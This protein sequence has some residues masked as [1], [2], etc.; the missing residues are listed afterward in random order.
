MRPSA[1][2]TNPTPDTKTMPVPE[3]T[4]LR[5]RPPARGQRTL[6]LLPALAAALLTAAA[7][8]AP[9]PVDPSRLPPAAARKI[10]F[11]KD[12]Q[13]ILAASCHRC[14]GP[15]KEKGGL[16][17]DAKS[18][19]LAGGTS[20]PVILPGD[21][22]ASPLIH[23]VSGLDPKLKMPA[24]GDPL[25]AEQVGILRAWID[26]GAD[27]PD[28]ASAKLPDKTDH[29][30]FK[31]V[32]RPT[33][34]DVSHK[35]WPRNDVDRFV[36]AALEKQNL[37]P[38][39]EADRRTLL[40]R[41]YFDLTGLPPTPEETDAFL[42]DKAPDAYDKLVDRLLASPRYGERWAR[43]WLDVVRFADSHGFEMNHERPNAWHYRD[44]VIRSLNDDKP[45]DRFLREQIAGD[46]LGADEAT[47]FLVGGPM[48][49]VKSPDPGL[50]AQQRADELHDMVATT[51]SAMLGLTVGCARCHDHKFDPVSHTDYYRI[52][53]VFEGVQHGERP[54]RLPPGDPRDAQLA[55]ARQRL[56]EIDAE[57]WAFEPVARVPAAGAADP[58]K[59]PPRRPAVRYDRNVDRFPPVV[60]KFVRLTVLETENASQPCIDELE[61][62][63]TGPLPPRNVALASA[64]AKAT[65]SGAL[66]GFD[67]HKIEHIND[68]RPGNG[69]SW[70]SDE[71]GTGWVQ[72]E[73]PEVTTIDRVAWGR[74]RE[75][76][77]RD[78]LATGYRIEVATEPGRWTLVA[79]GDDRQRFVPGDPNKAPS[80]ALPPEVQALLAEKAVLEARVGGPA[81][82]Q[83][84]YAGTFTPKP[85][86]TFRLHRGEPLQPR[87]PVAPGGLASV[88]PK[89]DLPANAPEQQRRAELAEW[90][91]DPEN[92]LPARVIVNR[93]WH[94]HF[95]QGIVNTPSDFGR[96]GAMPTHPALLDW[97]ASELVETHGWR[98]KPVHRL[99]VLS[100]T[101]RQSAA[102]RPDAA[103]RDAG[104][105]L[106]WR[107]PPRRLEAEAIRDSILAVSGNLDL[108]TMGGPGFNVFKPNDNY[109][110]VYEPR[111][112]FGPAEWRRMVY[113]R[114][115]RIHQDGTFGAFDC[116]DGAQIAPKRAS[117]TTPLQAL[118]LLNGG[119]IMQQ[120]DIFARRVQADVGADPAAQVTRAFR[121]ALGREP[122][123]RERDGAVKLVRDHGLVTL[124]RTL[125]NANEFLYVY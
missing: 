54:V 14:H 23:L 64:G 75:L 97:L 47:G 21:G 12:V 109:V 66:P 63:A 74:D 30:S 36:L 31:P 28:S 1:L 45:Y 3:P 43:H 99:I 22:A 113:Q 26:Q 24:E 34:P 83:M 117:S 118:N 80:D 41:V 52:K 115:P 42:A 67:I 71:A 85:N 116:P 37:S 68:G 35:D 91:T 55:A 46:A 49:M 70:I 60:A 94:Y 81:A 48:D 100:A 32:R 95:G 79:T 58:A 18:V 25:T 57:L 77:Y 105:T 13:P 29:W 73:L 65:A 51:G 10:D 90:L 2:V 120:S 6:L 89:L 103:A 15:E 4:R 111:E 38:S 122:D 5:H 9:A 93:L 125:F 33:V 112:T 27:W 40:R 121:L 96:M 72:I 102:S 110:R 59:A 108:T 17:L 101:Y 44:Y 61:V 19:A 56:K 98:L 104:T 11:V 16:R 78:R 119:F 84:A 107:Y 82:G 123:A 7:G 76:Q 87:E 62:Y 106:L 92:P 69:A 8:A 39:P 114:K 124:C 50:T 86:Q 20:G 53:A 88:G